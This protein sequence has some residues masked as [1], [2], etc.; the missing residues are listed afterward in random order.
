M[1]I[2]AGTVLFSGSGPFG[3][4]SESA[5]TVREA[6]MEDSIDRQ[7][8]DLQARS[9]SNPD[10]SSLL[11][12]LGFAY[13]QKSRENGDPSLYSKADGVFQQVLAISPNDPGVIT[14]VAAVALARHDFN[15]ALALAQQAIALDP[16]DADSHAVA[17]DAL[18]ELGRYADAEAEF[19]QVVDLRP[20]LSAF[21]RVAY[22]R[23]LH[24]DIAGARDSLEMAVEAGG[25]R[26][27]NAAYARVQLGNLLFNSGDLDGAAQQ[28]DDAL[29][30]FP[31]YVHA[32]AGLARVHGARGE[33]DEAIA[34]YKDVIARQPVLEYVIALGDTYSAAGEIDAAERQYA[35]VEAIDQL[36]R[37]SGV[38]TDLESA[39]F[40]ADR[41]ERLEESVAQARAIYETQPGS[42]RATDALAWTLHK[43]GRSAEAL[44]YARQ[45]T[46]LGSRDNNLLF[47]AGIIEKA[48]GDPARAR[49]LLQQVADANP[50]FS[51]VHAREAADTLAELTSLTEAR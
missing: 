5:T 10:D 50:A 32:L 3:N 13:L 31:G 35:L 42:V 21:I 9:A 11:T 22:L 29:E 36:Y 39:I 23:E 34:L 24:G 43:S 17:G 41:G 38:N 30:A 47:H 51:V 33:Y 6:Q 26:G 14:G 18:T 1:V 27:E 12:Q 15:S 2:A 45:S 8:G 44:E 7:I 19:Q 46:R 49:D 48:A 4:G 16:A 28:Y 25:P 37:S 40:L 20:D